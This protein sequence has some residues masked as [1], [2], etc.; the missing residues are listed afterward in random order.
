LFEEVGIIALFDE[1]VFAV[2]A[3]IVDVIIL[4]VMEWFDGHRIKNKELTNLEDLS[5]LANA[6]LT[7]H[8]FGQEGVAEFF[9]GA[10]LVTVC[11]NLIINWL[12]LCLESVNRFI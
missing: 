2:V 10:D 11:N 7:A 8:Q 6:H 4:P 5:I 12:N 9:K 3:A 1:Q